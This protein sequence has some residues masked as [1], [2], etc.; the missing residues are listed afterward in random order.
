MQG[1]LRSGRQA[2]TLLDEDGVGVSG[3]RALVV[4]AGVAGLGAA[5]KLRDQG[6][7]VTILE[8]RDR[9]GGRIHT[10]L[11]WGTPIEL[12]AT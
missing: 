1:A 2:A 12:G 9:V 8:A 7:E 4:G 6:A 11:S 3:R 5:T 10:N